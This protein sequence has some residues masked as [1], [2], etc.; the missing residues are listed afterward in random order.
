MVSEFP[1]WKGHSVQT[2]NFAFAVKRTDMSI[3]RYIFLLLL[4]SE[5]SENIL[6]YQLEVLENICAQMEK[7]RYQMRKMPELM[8]T[9][10]GAY[11]ENL[12]SD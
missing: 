9:H 10:F 6:S 8:P 11:R 2:R 5:N 12:S 3:L 4:P 7:D 1:I